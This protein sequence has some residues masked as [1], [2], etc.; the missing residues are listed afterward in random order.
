MPREHETINRSPAF[1]EYARLLVE[2]AQTMRERPGDESA[3]DELRDLIDAPGAMLTPEE[4]TF[5]HGLSRDLRMIEMRDV[6]DATQFFRRDEHLRDTAEALKHRR[7]E[8]LLRLLRIHNP[9]LSLDR[10]AYMRS[11]AYESLGCPHA[12]YAFMGYARQLVP[13]NNAYSAMTLLLSWG[14]LSVNRAVDSAM[15]AAFDERTS[16]DVVLA[17]SSVLARYVIQTTESPAAMPLVTTIIRKALEAAK[18]ARPRVTEAELSGAAALALIAARCQLPEDIEFAR[19]CYAEA[20]GEPSELD[21]ALGNFNGQIP[22]STDAGELLDHLST[23][24]FRRDRLTA[25]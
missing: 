8:Y 16:W 13:T 7:W 6:W 5:M 25:A 18:S 10:V 19:A 3:A 9:G 21:T 14:A 1:R 22:T 12:A 15:H 11:R 17:A 23:S 2:L 4:N 24:A 20:G